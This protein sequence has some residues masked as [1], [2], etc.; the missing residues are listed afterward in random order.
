MWCKVIGGW[1]EQAKRKET[2]VYRKRTFFFSFASLPERERRKPTEEQVFSPAKAGRSWTFAG[3][4]RRLTPPQLLARESAT[5]ASSLCTCTTERI[6][7]VSRER[8]KAD[9]PETRLN[10]SRETPAL[11]AT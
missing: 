6:T 3:G 1:V 11:L 8:T 2:S 4:L 9:V 5:E 7:A 10:L